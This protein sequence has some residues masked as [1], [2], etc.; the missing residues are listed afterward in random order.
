MAGLYIVD[1]METK[2]KGIDLELIRQAQQGRPSSQSVLA[3]LTK[4]VVFPY[5]YRLTFNYHLAE[6]LCQE[7]LIQMHKSLTELDFNSRQAFLAWIYR[8]A[9]SKVQKHHRYQKNR[10]FHSI[11]QS[12]TTNLNQGITDPGP[13]QMERMIQKELLQAAVAAMRTMK[14]SYRNI[15][16]LRC[17][18]ALSYDEI[19]AIEGR[20]RL[21]CRIMFCKAKKTL[22]K[23]LARRGFDNS[24]LLSALTLI[25][26][27][28]LSESTAAVSATAPVA[29]G[30]LS[31]GTGVSL[32]SVIVSKA[33]LLGIIC[34]ATGFVAVN[35]G[36]LQK[37]ND[38]LWTVR[39]VSENVKSG[40]FACPSQLIRYGIPQ[41]ARL[42]SIDPSVPGRT[43]TDIDISKVAEC[44]NVDDPR[45]VRMFRRYWIE[46]AFD[47][48]SLL[49]GPG[50]DVFI[51][52]NGCKDF[53]VILTDGGDRKYELGYH[54][55]I[56]NHTQEETM[57]FDL[58][59]HNIGFE[60]KA[61][62]LYV[63]DA[64][65]CGMELQSISARTRR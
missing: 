17:F 24:Y 7:T 4:Q 23:N 18:D 56:V 32:L 61:V 11:R 27:A 31:A 5:L 41:S 8:T 53:R 46:C 6:D 62:R 63:N 52:A 26:T 15:L 55:C 65:T 64:D 22:R 44:L 30:V 20:S 28:T 50:P 54:S 42:T 10:R 43:E 1:Y 19:A 34:L 49:D 3:E 21:A 13:D 36:W 35:L 25:G 40:D 12:S 48:N 33:S 57:P 38:S 29:V 9:L 47:G 37:K 39:Q 58:R 16:T 2:S 51:T 59:G 14:L 60:P 45:Y